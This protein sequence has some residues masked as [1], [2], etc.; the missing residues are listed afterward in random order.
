AN[1]CNTT[2]EELAVGVD[3]VTAA[4]GA[5]ETVEQKYER[6]FSARWSGRNVEVEKI[7]I[8]R[9]ETNALKRW[10]CWLPQKSSRKRLTVRRRQPPRCVKRLCF[11]FA[12]CHAT[13]FAR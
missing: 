7:A 11:E 4:R 13:R 6:R 8:G 12:C 5:L 3:R 10:R 2:Q 9:I 1:R